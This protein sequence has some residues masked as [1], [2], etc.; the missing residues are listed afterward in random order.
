MAQLHS[1]NDTRRELRAVLAE[2]QGDASH[3]NPARR[4]A[5]MMA[6][7][8]SADGAW[9]HSNENA[10]RFMDAF[11]CIARRM[12]GSSSIH[13]DLRQRLAAVVNCTERD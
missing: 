10:V 7:Q 12:S 2:Q 5:F 3:R 11:A 8:I 6:E 13:P 4:F 9:Y 1:I